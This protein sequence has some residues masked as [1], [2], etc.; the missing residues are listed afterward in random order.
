VETTIAHAEHLVVAERAQILAL[1]QRLTPDL[2]PE[3]A[4]RACHPPLMCRQ[5]DAAARPR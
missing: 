5:R 1:E 4:R 2:D 3:E